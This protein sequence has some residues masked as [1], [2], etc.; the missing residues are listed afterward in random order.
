MSCNGGEMSGS[1]GLRCG[2]LLVITPTE[3]KLLVITPT[4]AVNTN[5]VCSRKGIN[6]TFRVE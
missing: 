4:M 3:V 6:H 5:N 1:G 2:L